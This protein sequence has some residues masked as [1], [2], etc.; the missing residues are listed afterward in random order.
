V[1]LGLVLN[2]CDALAIIVIIVGIVAL[3]IVKT[4]MKPLLI[5]LL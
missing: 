4:M 1:A 2:Q 3:S 5:D